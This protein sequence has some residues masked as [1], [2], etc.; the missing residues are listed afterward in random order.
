G[1]LAVTA[2]SD[3]A[4]AALVGTAAGGAVGVAG[5]VVVS[6]VE[7]TTEAFVGSGARAT[8]IN[9]D[10]RFQ[11]GGAFA[12]GAGQTVR[13]EADDT[14]RLDDQSGALAGGAVGVGASIDVSAVRNRT[15]ASVGQATQI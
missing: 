4:L 8:L 11:S 5:T 1:A 15:V 7:T 13:I 12:P 2:N 6:T 10:P 14:A 9:Q 3:E